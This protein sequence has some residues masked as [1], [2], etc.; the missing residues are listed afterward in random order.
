[1][2]TRGTLVLASL[3]ISAG[4]LT[5]CEEV[6]APKNDAAPAAPA[7]AAFDTPEAV[8]KAMIAAGSAMDKEGLSKVFAP[9]GSKEFQ[10]FVTKEAKS[11][12]YE[13]FAKFVKDATV[14]EAKIEGDTAVVSVKFTKRDEKI[15][16][17]KKDGRWWV[18]DF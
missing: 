6:P 16:C 4:L 8:V 7:A 13:S 17:A 1:M 12:E 11:E 5:A 18:V 15:S 2:N 10:P 3:L 9:E 14:G